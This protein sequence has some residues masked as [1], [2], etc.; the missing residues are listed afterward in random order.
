MKIDKNRKLYV[1]SLLHDGPIKSK[2]TLVLT[3]SEIKNS[4][5]KNLTNLFMND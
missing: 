1:F 3:R 2:K 4:N 5:E